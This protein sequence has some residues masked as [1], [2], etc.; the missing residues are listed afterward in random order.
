M[1]LRPPSS[2]LFPYTTLF[3]SRGAAPAGGQLLVGSLDQSLV[4]GDERGRLEDLLR[5]VVGVAGL[6]LEGDRDRLERRLDVGERGLVVLDGRLGRRRPDRRCDLHHRPV[7]R[8]RADADAVASLGPGHGAHSASRSRDRSA[9]SESSASSAPSPSA[10]STTSSPNL[11]PRAIT[12]RMLVA[13]TA[14]SPG[15][16]ISTSSPES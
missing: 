9:T 12:P 8:P 3:R 11:A 16:P 14:S 10:V 1:I 4:A 15:R 2:T 6:P 7:G 13:S 5:R